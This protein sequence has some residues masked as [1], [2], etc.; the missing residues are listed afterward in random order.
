MEKAHK[1]ALEGLKRFIAEI[2]CQLKAILAR[3]WIQCCIVFS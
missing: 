3:V 1:A 2:E